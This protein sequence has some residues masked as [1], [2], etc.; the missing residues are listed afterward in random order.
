M[1]ALIHFRRILT[2]R[3]GINTE[4]ERAIVLAQAACLELATKFY[5]AMPRELRD[6]VYDYLKYLAIKTREGKD[7][8]SRYKSCTKLL[9]DYIG[10]CAYPD[11]V[12]L[13]FVDK[14]MQHCFPL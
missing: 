11:Y 12:G 4:I 1:I 3:R 10:H 9:A 14:M 13:D 8:A 6:E 7:I 5:N 2:F